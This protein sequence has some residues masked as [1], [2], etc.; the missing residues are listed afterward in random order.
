MLAGVM[1]SLGLGGG[2]A[3]LA[4]QRAARAQARSRGAA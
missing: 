2:S 4:E 3:L 1:I